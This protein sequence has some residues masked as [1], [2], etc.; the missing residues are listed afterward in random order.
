[1][2]EEVVIFDGVE[3]TCSLSFSLSLRMEGFGIGTR[4]FFVSKHRSSRS[5][6]GRSWRKHTMLFPRQWSIRWV[7]NIRCKLQTRG[8]RTFREG[9]SYFIK[10][11][12]S[13]GFKPE[14]SVI[15]NSLALYVAPMVLGGEADISIL[16][17][18][19]ETNRELLE[20]RDYETEIFDSAKAREHIN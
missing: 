12:Q 19:M 9:K 10:K 13:Y 15:P 4:L 20:E 2:K 16:M 17:D 7:E 8:E 3:G 1:M 6:C 11:H 18:N 14:V 5:V